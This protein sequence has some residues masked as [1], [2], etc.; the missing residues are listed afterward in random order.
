MNEL[1]DVVARHDELAELDPATRRLALRSLLHRELADGAAASAVGQIADAIDAYGPLTPLMGE[2]DVTDVLING[3]HEV[4]VERSDRL[5]ASDANFGTT[6]ELQSFVR[7]LAV[8][9]GI[10]ADVSHPVADGRLP[11]GSRLHIVLPP[12]AQSGPLLSIR[13]FPERALRMDDL[14]ERAMLTS[15]QAQVLSN[16]VRDRRTMA[17]SG[18]TGTGKTTLLNALLSEIGSRERVVVIEE[19][20][21][22]NPSCPHWVSLLSRPANVEGEGEVTLDDLLRAS[23]RMRPDRI[24]VGEIRGPEARTALSAMSVG[25]EGSMVTLHARSS[26]DLID[27]FVSLALTKGSGVSEAALR[28]QVASALSL[29]IHVGRDQEGRRKV[30][31]LTETS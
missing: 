21:E 8:R 11:D 23:L 29:L 20:A 14:L 2:R 19:T 5:E 13:R 27:R 12:I 17:I 3:P 7:R 9:A 30:L 25:H 28:R 1:F 31:D 4:W 22:L 24:V 15:D 26:A 18:G 10:R 16:A 6:E